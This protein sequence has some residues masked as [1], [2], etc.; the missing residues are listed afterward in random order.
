MKIAFYGSSLVSAYW[1]GAATYYRG[2]LRA[3]AEKGYD[4]TFYEPDVYDR[5]KNRD[6]DPPDWCRLVVYEGT[7]DAL[8]AVTSEAVE[9]DIV[10]KASG[11]GFEDDRLLEEVLRHARPH[12]LKI[13]WDV[14]APATLAELRANPDHPLRLALARLDLV[15]T[16]G[17]GDP[18]VNAYRS[19][20]AAECV[21]IYNA[22]DPQTHHP[23]PQDYRFAADLG[24]LG[25]RLP[26]REARVEHFFLEPASRLPNRTFL[27]GGSGWQD[28][29]IPSNVRYIGH[30]PTRDHNAFNVTPMT[31]LNISR[32]SMAENGFSPATRVFEAAG[33]GA[34]LITDYWEG[35]DVFLKSGEEVL[36]ARDGQ[37][38]AALLSGLSHQSARE[39]GERARRRVLA[40]HTYVNRAETADEIFRARLGAREAAE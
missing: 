35:I 19:V 40:E 14:D 39:I 1:N 26:D 20:G 13:F 12:A 22:L 5:Q 28:K 9:A 21:P 8:K 7:I 11:V 33:A 3:L 30:V 25:N 27:L 17:G 24:F 38:V 29:P 18:V 34:C 6:M 15:L 31:V 16:Y 32:A 4:I 37:D 36:V 10:V 2:L 23:V